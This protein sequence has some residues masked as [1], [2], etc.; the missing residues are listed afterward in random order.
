MKAES[1][2]SNECV[3]DPRTSE[4]MR[5][6]P[7]SK[8]NE[9]APVRSAT[10]RK[11]RKGAAPSESRPAPGRALIGAVGEQPYGSGEGEIQDPG[12]LHGAWQPQL[13][14]HDESA[15]QH[16][17]R[18]PEAVGEIEHR[19]RLTGRRRIATDQPGAHQRESR[20]EEDRLRQN[21]QSREGPFEQSG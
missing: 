19:E 8:T 13:L 4:S 16:A 18:R 7:I 14:D 11:S 5:I 3:E 15:C 17:D 21:Q 10:A 12:G 2:N 1:I 6:Q 20:A 9:A